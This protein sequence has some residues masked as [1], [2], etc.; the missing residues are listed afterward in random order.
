M[1]GQADQEGLQF[2][3]VLPEAVDVGRQVFDA[4]SPEADV[5]P[6]AKVFFLVGLQVKPRLFVND[7]KEPAKTGTTDRGMT[8]RPVRSTEEVPANDLSNPY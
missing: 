7:T 2:V 4:R 8:T 6:P 3:F 1:N 5:N